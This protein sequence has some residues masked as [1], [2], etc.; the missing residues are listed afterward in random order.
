MSALAATDAPSGEIKKYGSVCRSNCNFACRYLANA[1]DGTIIK[2]EVGDY[3]DPD[4]TS[5]CLKG[6]PSIERIYSP[7]RGTKLICIDPHQVRYRPPVRPVH[8][9]HARQ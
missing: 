9:H 2:L 5:C 4:Y 1:V 7:G 6:L 3:D 8:R